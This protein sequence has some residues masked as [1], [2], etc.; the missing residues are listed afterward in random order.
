MNKLFLSPEAAR[1]ISQIKQYISI[2]LKNRGAANRIVG[3]I[4]KELRA[5]ERYPLQGPSIEALTGFQTDLRMLLCGKHIALYSVEK[6]SVFVARVLDARQ[7]YLRVLFGDEYW[8]QA[9][10]TQQR[11]KAAKSLFGILSD[12]PGSPEDQPNR[13][14]IAAMREAERI[15]ND[16][17]VSTKKDCC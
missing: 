11:I 2:E 8:N 15:A 13:E 5:L 16:P 7:D 4:L 6:E 12:I 14:T 3:T 1:D 10:D 9:N 17:S